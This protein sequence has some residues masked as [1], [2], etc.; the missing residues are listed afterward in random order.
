MKFGL[1]FSSR[2]RRDPCNNR[3]VGWGIRTKS[4]KQDG[5]PSALL[6]T[7]PHLIQKITQAIAVAWLVNFKEPWITKRTE[8]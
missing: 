8:I 3:S 2:E 7:W 4:Q 6:I 5:S 1:P